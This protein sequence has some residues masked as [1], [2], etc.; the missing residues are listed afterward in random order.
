MGG[1]NKFALALPIISNDG[2]SALENIHYCKAS[3]IIN[4]IDGRNTCIF[5]LREARAFRVNSRE[6]DFGVGRQI[7]PTRAELLLLRRE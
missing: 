4:C 2:V 1:N 7:F 6:D 3:I 5:I